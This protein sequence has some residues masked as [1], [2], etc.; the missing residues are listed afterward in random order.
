MQTGTILVVMCM[1]ALFGREVL[2]ALCLAEHDR[3]CSAP[4]GP[5]VLVDMK[6]PNSVLAPFTVLTVCCKLCADLTV[7]ATPSAVHRLGLAKAALV[8]PVTSGGMICS[9]R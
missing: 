7:V 1:V 9:K 8:G 6:F 3:T 5:L 4:V 2:H